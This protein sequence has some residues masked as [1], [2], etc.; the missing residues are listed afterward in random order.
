VHSRIIGVQMRIIY[1]MLF[2]YFRIIASFKSRELILLS[3]IKAILFR[4]YRI[5]LN[6]V[7][8]VK[9]LLIKK[10]HL[11]QKKISI[12][13]YFNIKYEI[14]IRN[15]LFLGYSFVEE[16]SLLK[17]LS[18]FD[19]DVVLFDFGS[20]SFILKTIRATNDLNN[21]LL[22]YLI[23]KTIMDSSLVPDYKK[24]IIVNGHCIVLFENIKH[25]D[26]KNNHKRYEEVLEIINT[27]H[28]KSWQN[29]T[30]EGSQ[31][32]LFKLKEFYYSQLYK[33]LSL[34]FPG[35]TMENSIQMKLYIKDIFRLVFFVRGTM[36]SLEKIE[37]SMAHNDLNPYN[38]LFDELTNKMIIIDW[39][40]FY[41][42]PVYLDNAYYLSFLETAII[43]EYL[44]SEILSNEK[45][46]I[47]YYWLLVYN[48]FLNN[49][50]RTDLHELNFI[51]IKELIG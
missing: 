41:C 3:R 35:I 50:N 14:D 18:F 16:V 9:L 30:I 36:D 47:L 4:I 26:Y 51:K 48:F 39:E 49:R 13:N 20:L 2:Y 10:T 11:S 8:Y 23:V 28:R 34:D 40:S 45:N 25:M 46:K 15:E 22:S 7:K 21:E 38:L 43:N 5:I 42:S 29:I 24:I 12:Y 1:K 19:N 27:L 44:S 32:V 31:S 6:P 33:I 17:P 37:F